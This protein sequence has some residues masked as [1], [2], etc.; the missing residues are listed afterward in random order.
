LPIFIVLIGEHLCGDQAGLAAV[1]GVFA[2]PHVIGLSLR[3]LLLTHHGYLALPGVA[4]LGAELPGCLLY[5]DGR[6]QGGPTALHGADR[7]GVTSGAGEAA[8]GSVVGIVDVG[9]GASGRVEHAGKGAG[10]REGVG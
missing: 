2:H 5:P 9:V 4:P 8:Q 3:D 7:A 1:L 10:W 6:R